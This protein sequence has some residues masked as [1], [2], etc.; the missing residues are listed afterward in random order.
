MYNPTMKTETD[1]I[2]VNGIGPNADGKISFAMKQCFRKKDGTYR[3]PDY[4]EVLSDGT[5]INTI[6][7]RRHMK[8]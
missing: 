7:L 4:V 8:T 2:A 1:K 6:E 5:W 3:V